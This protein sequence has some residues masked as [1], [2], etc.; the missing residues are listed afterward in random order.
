MRSRLR[1]LC[2]CALLAGTSVVSRASA[3]EPAFPDPTDLQPL[4]VA[5]TPTA[6]PPVARFADETTETPVA[7]RLSGATDARTDPTDAGQLV[8]HL[9]PGAIVTRIASHGTAV[10]V[11]LDDPENGYTRLAWVPG[12]ALMQQRW[13]LPAAPAPAV[14]LFAQGL[15]VIPVHLDAPTDVTLE[16]RRSDGWVVACYAPC[17]ISLPLEG[18]YR[19]HGEGL[20]ASGAFTLSPV[21]GRAVI[22]VVPA[23][24]GGGAGFALVGLGGLV[25]V[26]GVVILAAGFLSSF[27]SETHSATMLAGVG[28]MA[29][30]GVIGGLGGV[31]LATSKKT[32]V[33]QG[34]A[35]T[36]ARLPTWNAGVERTPQSGTSFAIPL[37]S[38]SF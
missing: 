12:D 38:G 2:V 7:V 14:P 9:S 10:L 35:L 1:M 4:P 26:V 8:A 28:V 16:L 22:H 21:G 33:R 11:E 13:Q 15:A 23:P 37:L 19:T 30:G 32:V 25:L 20:R 36:S 29:G 27:M 18:K 31:L 6:R 17:N 24:A 5:P 3:Q 34:D